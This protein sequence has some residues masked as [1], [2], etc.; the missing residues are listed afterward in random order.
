MSLK[1]IAVPRLAKCCFLLCVMAFTMAPSRCGGG[2]QGH[3]SNLPPGLTQS[4]LQAAAAVLRQRTET[5]DMVRRFKKGGFNADQIEFVM[6]K[7]DGPLAKTNAT[8]ERIR[9]D[10]EAAPTAQD[11]SAFRTQASDAVGD[12]VVLDSLL[13]TALRPGIP[14]TQLGNYVLLNA[15]SLPDSWVAVWKA[16]RRLS[17]A[18]KQQFLAYLDKELKWKTWQAIK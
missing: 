18:D 1:G 10:I 13:E 15:N 16:S 9:Q 8:V 3:M 7:Y 5:E 2:G 12:C 6:S 17:P 11:E 14:P 4:D